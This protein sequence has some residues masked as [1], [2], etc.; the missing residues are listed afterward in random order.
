MRWAVIAFGTVLLVICLWWTVVYL[1][2][3]AG[4]RLVRR[5]D[6]RETHAAGPD[7]AADSREPSEP[8]P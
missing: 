6:S 2:R 1:L 8:K 5:A 3:R 7:N 4:I